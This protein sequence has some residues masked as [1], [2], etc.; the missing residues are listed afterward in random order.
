[1]QEATLPG[2]SLLPLTGFAGN[3]TKKFK[4]IL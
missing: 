1:M 3:K 2:L 4:L